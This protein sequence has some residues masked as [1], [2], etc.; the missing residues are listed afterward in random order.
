M[1]TQLPCTN[2]SYKRKANEGD[3]STQ[4]RFGSGRG[5]EKTSLQFLRQESQQAATRSPS[6]TF[7]LFNPL[8]ALRSK[9]LYTGRYVLHLIAQ[10][11]SQ[12]RQSRALDTTAANA[13][14][15]ATL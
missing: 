4:F 7:I 1:A 8:L 12:S 14:T 3:E 13:T 6:V 11:A 10:P 5:V 2:S 15:S 9:Q